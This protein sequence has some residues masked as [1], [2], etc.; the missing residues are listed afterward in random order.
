MVQREDEEVVKKRVQ[1]MNRVRAKLA[2]S[3]LS[4]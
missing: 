1:K 2:Y 4:A 3:G